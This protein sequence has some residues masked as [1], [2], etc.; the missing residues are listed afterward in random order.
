MTQPPPRSSPSD[1][2]FR[3]EPGGLPLGPAYE[4]VDEAELMWA[5]QRLELRVH[6]LRARAR[7]A[8]G[9]DDRPDRP[10]HQG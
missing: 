7:G 4:L 2:R 9:R 3:R 5:M 1:L 8:S 10:P 6:D